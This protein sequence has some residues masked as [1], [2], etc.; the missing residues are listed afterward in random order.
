[1]RKLG[2]NKMQIQG[3]INVSVF[4]NVKKVGYFCII[5]SEK[6][7]S[8]STLTKRKKSVE[9][10]P[11]ICNLLNLYVCLREMPTF[12]FVKFKPSN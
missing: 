7:T 5:Y 10:I 6:E 3:G 1:M 8:F 4:V 12:F 9:N 2:E 11:K